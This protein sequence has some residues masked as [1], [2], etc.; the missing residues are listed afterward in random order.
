MLTTSAFYDALFMWWLI[1][2]EQSADR[3]TE[4]SFNQSVFISLSTTGNYNQ[5]DS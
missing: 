4:N 3:F 1:Y 5:L 2:L